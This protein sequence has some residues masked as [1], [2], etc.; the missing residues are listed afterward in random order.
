LLLQ[1][2]TNVRGK[3]YLEQAIAL[4]PNYSEPHADLGMYYLLVNINGLRP[5]REMAPLARA[6]ARK[7]LEL[8]PD[9]PRAHILLGLM[10]A[11]NAT[12][13]PPMST[14]EGQGTPANSR[15]KFG[16]ALLWRLT[17]HEAAALPKPFAKPRSR[18]N[19]TRLTH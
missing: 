18:S 15:R 4:D 9:E 17:F 11:L 13:G 16:C 6:E 10:A 8:N 5:L 19:K 7:A 2:L 12:G 14:L 3:E 1:G